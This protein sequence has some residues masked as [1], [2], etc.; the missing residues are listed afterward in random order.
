MRDNV[1]MKTK[2][3]IIVPVY[4]VEKYIS[5]CLD[6]LINQTYK[7]IEI[8]LVDDG[9]QDK[10]RKF[11]KEYQ[12][13]DSRIKAVFKENEG[14]ST[15]RNIGIDNSLGELICFVDSDDYVMSDYV[16]HLVKLLSKDDADIAL[17]TEMFGTFDSNQ[18]VKSKIQTVDGRN[19]AIKLLL[20]DIP[21]GV[22]SK[23]F[24]SSFLKTKNIQFKKE[25]FIGE[26]FNFNIDAF[27]QATKVTIGN[28]KIYYYRRDN[29]MS[30]TTKFSIQKWENGLKAL[31]IIKKNLVFSDDEI[32]KSWKFA[33][34][35]THSD[36]YD[37]MVLSS[38]E[39]DYPIFFKKM[40]KYTRN[41]AKIAFEVNTSKKQKMRAFVLIL[42]PKLVP[43]MMTIRK[44]SN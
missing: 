15:A 31:Q 38:V 35:R 26:G 27:Q 2:V 29:E 36:V 34:W 20:Y 5:K 11:I 8:V 39:N 14:V 33:N 22:Y 3:S 32:E 25:L 6:S 4:N 28:R 43:I 13:K 41:K 1:E 24:K 23:I 18:V 37:I 40:K 10:S 44:K 30:A 9:S 42:Y 16:E 17:T 7:N 12:K 19:A 21:I